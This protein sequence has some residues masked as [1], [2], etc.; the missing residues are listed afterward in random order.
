MASGINAMLLNEHIC[1]VMKNLA[2]SKVCTKTQFYVVGPSVPVWPW[3]ACKS[4]AICSVVITEV[5]EFFI[6]RWRLSKLRNERL[7]K[8]NRA[9]DRTAHECLW[10]TSCPKKQKDNCSIWKRLNERHEVLYS[11]PEI[12]NLTVMFLSPHW[13]C[14]GVPWK[15]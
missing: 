14:P 2:L 4:L 12:K 11:D 3:V 13:W 1:A 5:M 8:P 9:S 6:P 15:K 7:K 10:Q